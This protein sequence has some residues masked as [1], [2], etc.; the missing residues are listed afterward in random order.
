[1]SWLGVGGAYVA[2]TQGSGLLKAIH[3]RRGED[4]ARRGQRARKPSFFLSCDT[5]FLF[6]EKKLGRFLLLTINERNIAA[7]LVVHSRTKNANQEL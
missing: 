4:G 6:L 3:G 2:L 5:I 1:M 7:F